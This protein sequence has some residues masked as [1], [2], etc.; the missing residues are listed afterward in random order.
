MKDINYL[1]I[2]VEDI[3]TTI[4]AT[5]DQEG[6]P[7]TRAI[8]MMLWDDKGVYFITA[9]GKAFYKQLQEQKYISLSAVKDKKAI[10]L[11]GW[12]RNIGNEKLDMIFEKN[13]YMKKIYPDD[14]RSA[15]DVF[16]LYDA[17]G[18]FFDISDPSHIIRGQISIGSNKRSVSGY[19]IEDK[20]IGCGKC[21][22]VCPQ[23]CIDIS[24][25][26]AVIDQSHCLHCGR[27][28]EICPVGAIEIR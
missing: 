20:C 15:I 19:F 17:Q 16:H 8:D 6:H 9:R 22:E 25:I 28:L 24:H 12:V 11:S 4:V 21:L 2:L 5:I 26:P 27:C 3:H 13:T 14:T 10:S 1:K 23:R 7:I 18:E